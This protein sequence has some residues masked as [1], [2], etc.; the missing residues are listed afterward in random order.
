M[1]A[2]LTAT[3]GPVTAPLRFV[4]LLEIIGLAALPL[5][6]MVFARLPRGAVAFAKPLGLVTVGWLTWLSG[7]LGLG[8]GPATTGVAV[9]LVAAAGLAA[10]WPRRRDLAACLRSRE[11]WVAEA[12]L[13]VSLAA[14]AVVVAHAPDVW[15][16]EKPMD[17]ALVNAIAASDALPP[18]NPWFAG[19]DLDGYYYF[20]HLLVAVMIQATG[21]EPTVGYNTALAAFF[22]LAGVAAH[23]LGSA[24]AGLTEAPRALTG[25][26]TMGL[27]LVAGNLASAVLLLEFDGPLTSYDWFQASRV[28]PG[29]INEFP[30]FSWLLGDLHAH[31]MAVPLTLTALALALQWLHAG[32][33][34]PDTA[35]AAVLTGL[36]YA[37]NSWSYP[38]VTGLLLLALLAAPGSLARR[39]AHA[40]L[41][42][43]GGALAVLP[44]LLAFEPPASGIGLVDDRRP[45]LL[46]VRDGAL[47]LGL[48]AWLAAGAF[49]AAALALPRSRLL[50]LIAVVAL[51][52]VLSALSGAR[53]AWTALLL[54]LAAVAAWRLLA[55]SSTA[56]GRFVWLMLFGG[57][58]C[59]AIPEVVYISDAFS[60]G[61]LERMNTVFKLGYQAWLLLAVGGIA[62]LVVF[63]GGLPAAARISW[64]GGA[65][66]L[67]VAS[68]AFPLAG[69]H[70][71][72]GGFSAVPTLSGL[73]WLA[74]SA[75]GDVAAI[76]WLRAHAEPS[77]VVLESA[78]DDYSAA[79]HARISTFTGR[80]TVIGWEGHVLQWGEDPGTRRADVSRLYREPSASVAAPLLRA[81]GV[82]Y[83]VSGPLER[84]DHGTV[85]E[86]KWDAL[87]TRVFEQAGTTIWRLA[88]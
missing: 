72:T 6:V 30:A 65:V 27:V 80:S 77:A 78:G 11:F 37:T 9:V 28:V 12:V 42:L 82:D 61:A 38:V 83:V 13:V 55:S 7:T 17:M 84:A 58:L 24:L 4:L 25:L 59:T 34:I 62:A 71:R 16:T 47:T 39:G 18:R 21:V 67:A 85:G 79:G 60:G 15:G 49:L 53:L 52:M 10:A 66:V 20:G 22:A 88:R 33:R 5:T 86:A 87:G 56:A 69:S 14:L 41:L 68:A 63:A 23:G 2:S 50:A 44:F 46:A 36:L 45:L 19:S 75:P 35:A 81:Y 57:L 70:A 32:A 8:H 48:P 64:L 76:A 43:A 73:R 31:V 54:A 26:L 3:V 1:A 74:A 29:T 51:A 40:G